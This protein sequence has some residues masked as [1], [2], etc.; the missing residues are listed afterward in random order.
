MPLAQRRPRLELPRGARIAEAV[1]I[2]GGPLE[3]YGFHALEVLQS[4]VEARQGGETGVTS[5]EY[6]Q[7]ARL[8]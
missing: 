4:F 8:W 2:H 5:V 6:L 1:S 7:G 3:A